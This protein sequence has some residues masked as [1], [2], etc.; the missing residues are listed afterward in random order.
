[1]AF[2]VQV[3]LLKLQVLLQRNLKLS[4]HFYPTTTSGTQAVISK[5]HNPHNLYNNNGRMDHSIRHL[6]WPTLLKQ[7]QAAQRRRRNSSSKRL[8]NSN[9]N[10]IMHSHLQWASYL[11]HRRTCNT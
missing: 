3:L 6:R 7:A 9:R 10:N 11:A 1:M 5:A 2:Q 8:L 4:S